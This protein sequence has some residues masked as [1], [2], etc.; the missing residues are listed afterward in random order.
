MKEKFLQFFTGKMS[1]SIYIS[2]AAAVV[3]GAVVITSTVIVHNNNQKIDSVLESLSASESVAEL[4][5]ENVTE[6][7]S[8]ADNTDSGAQAKAPN[9]EPAGDKALQ[10]LAEYDKLTK[11]YERKRVELIKQK[12]SVPY[13]L[14]TDK[15][16]EAPKYSSDLDTW[17]KR[18]EFMSEVL[19]WEDESRAYDKSVSIA[20]SKAK[21]EQANEQSEIQKQIDAL[22]AQYEKDVAAL[23]ARYGIA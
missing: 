1:K 2:I 19:K 15:F 13:N 21:E 10:Y 18:E 8:S 23:K 4:S 16:R 9:G 7:V 6:S 14:A 5:S 11:E 17:D 3:C 20:V 22:D 12:D